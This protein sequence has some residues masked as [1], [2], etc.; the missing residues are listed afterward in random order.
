ML[1]EYEKSAIANNAYM[2]KIVKILEN[3][4]ETKKIMSKPNQYIIQISDGKNSVNIYQKGKCYCINLDGT[5]FSSLIASEGGAYLYKNKK[6]DVEYRLSEVVLKEQA[7]KRT[8]FVKIKN[9]KNVNSYIDDNGKYIF[10]Y[11]DDSDPSGERITVYDKMLVNMDEKSL[12]NFLEAKSMADKGD[13]K[14][15]ELPQNVEDFDYSKYENDDEFEDVD[16]KILSDLDE[17][18]EEMNFEQMSE[19]QQYENQMEY[20]DDYYKNYVCIVDNEEAFCEEKV[21]ILQKLDESLQQ[22]DDAFFD[23][24]D[25]VEY[26]ITVYETE[27]GKFETK[28]AS[29]K[30]IDNKSNNKIKKEQDDDLEQ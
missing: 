17:M 1:E 5:N 11:S 26:I 30:N 24:T 20:W 3:G 27:K 14:E 16:E 8:T 4:K 15:E 6:L 19:K 25:C 28:V 10:I 29:S 21:Q 12:C 18:V 9:Y 22:Y 2:K 23:I 7:S 13:S